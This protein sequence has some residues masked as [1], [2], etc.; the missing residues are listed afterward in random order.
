MN[1]FDVLG[2][3]MV[4]PGVIA[5]EATHAAVARLLGAQTTWV[6]EDGLP[7]TRLGWP[8][9]VAAWR[10]RV[11]HLAPTLVSPVAAGVAL[12]LTGFA[13]SRLPEVW[14]AV[15]AVVVAGN[16]AVFVFPSASDR[17]PEVL[18]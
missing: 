15:V 14:F 4:A 10:I 6:V 8:P 7:Q 3:V 2:W 9:A 13:A 17:R 1:V 12:V 18:A 16:V 5:H 11:A